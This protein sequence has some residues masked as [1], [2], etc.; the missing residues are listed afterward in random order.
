MKRQARSRP[1]A[2]E[3]PFPSA[4]PQDVKPENVVM[5]REGVVKLCD[6]GLAIDCSTG[7]VPRSRV[8]TPAYMAPGA[9]AGLS[10]WRAPPHSR[11]RVLLPSRK[12]RYASGEQPGPALLPLIQ[13]LPHLPFL[14]PSLPP[15]TRAG[16]A[17]APLSG[18]R[19]GNTRSPA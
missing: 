17:P 14:S 16:P 12:P 5:T 1:R 8:G 2:A 10:P 7:A 13:V 9:R 15:S 3:I 19:G 18:R 6:F 11:L 4:P